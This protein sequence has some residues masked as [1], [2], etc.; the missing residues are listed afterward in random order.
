MGYGQG[1]RFHR[2]ARREFDDGSIIDATLCGRVLNGRDSK[3][4]RADKDVTCS[5]CR[6]V[7]NRHKE[8]GAGE[9]DA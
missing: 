6:E 7:I 9:S 3:I 8:K 4:A 1:K 2:K 5:K